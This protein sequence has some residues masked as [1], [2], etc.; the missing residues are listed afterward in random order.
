MEAVTWWFSRRAL[1]KGHDITLITTK[2]S[3]MAGKCNP[4]TIKRKI[5]DAKGK[6]NKYYRHQL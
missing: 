4:K 5:T 6:K 3:P 2:G 1:E